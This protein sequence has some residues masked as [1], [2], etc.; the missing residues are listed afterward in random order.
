MPLDTPPRGRLNTGVRR[1]GV[2]LRHR[3]FRLFWTGQLVS[4]AGTWMQ[5]VAQGWLV[6]QLTNDAFLLGVVTAAQ[7]FPVLVFGL[8]GGLIADALPKRRTLIATQAASMLLA[9]VLGLLT[10]TGLVQVWQ[11]VVLALLLGTVNAFDMPTRQAFVI[12]M[13]G[14]ADVVNAVGL[15]SAAFNGARIVGPAIGGLVI[16]AVGIAACF[17]IN[18]ASFVA[19]IASL[20]LMREGEL[21]PFVAARVERT[22]GAVV[23]NLAE[24]LRYVRRTRVVL[25]AVVV[26]GLVSM[27]GMNFTVIMPVLARDVLGVEASGLGFLMAATGVG[28]VASA[29]SIAYLGRPSPRFILAGAAIAGILEIAVAFVRSFPLALVCAAGIGAGAIGMAATANTTIQL[30]VPDELRGRAMS[31][32]TTVFTGTAPFGGLLIGAMISQYGAPAAFVFGGTASLLVAAVAYLVSRP[33]LR[34]ALA[35]RISS[36]RA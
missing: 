5:V 30:A 31:V 8:F 25:L 35:P 33:W 29:L 2:A 1:G 18:A 16:G 20:L 19:V 3:N 13:V 21:R 6:L 11:I 23:E 9:L 26:V 28:S 32:F 10:A 27:F 22:A 12:E 4:L 24:G 17:F 15:N 36:T 7:F 34:T 14:R